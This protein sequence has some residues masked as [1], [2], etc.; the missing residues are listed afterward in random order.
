MD[1]EEEDLTF[2]FK[3]P[4]KHSVSFNL[5]SPLHALKLL[6][7]NSDK[8]PSEDDTEAAS[9]DGYITFGSK[10]LDSKSFTIV[11]TKTKAYENKYVHFSIIASTSGANLRL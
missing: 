9:M 8:K 6:V 2:T 3:I 5:I 10:D 11:V 7:N 1:D 4:E